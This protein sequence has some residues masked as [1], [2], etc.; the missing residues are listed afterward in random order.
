MSELKEIGKEHMWADN[1][2]INDLIANAD[3]VIMVNS[4]VGMEGILHGKRVACFGDADYDSVV[5]KVSPSSAV[6]KISS[7]LESVPDIDNYRNFINTY[8]AKL[9][10]SRPRY[11]HN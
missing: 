7:L 3:A 8:C 1:V 4:G 5:C 2:N 11:S 9:Y 6:D 10:D